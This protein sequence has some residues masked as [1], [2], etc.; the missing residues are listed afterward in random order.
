VIDYTALTEKY[1]RRAGEALAL[2][3]RTTVPT[4]RRFV[5]MGVVVDVVGG[6]GFSI[7]FLV[8][9]FAGVGTLIVSLVSGNA[10][11]IG[12]SFVMIISGLVCAAFTYWLVHR[13]FR[14]T[15][16]PELWWRLDRFATANGLVFAPWS[17][18]PAFPS[19]MFR[20][21]AGAATYSHIRRDGDDFFNIG[22]LYYQTGKRGNETFD[23]R[24][25][26]VAIKLEQQW[27]GMLLDATA[28]DRLG[29]NGIP[30]DLA[31]TKMQKVVGTGAD[32]FV[33]WA[34][35]GDSEKGRQVFSPA[36][37]EALASATGDYDAHL[38]ED[39]LFILSRTEFDMADPALLA[40]LF[41]F[42]DV[43]RAARV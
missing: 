31:G 26:F 22:N 9:F 2:R 35:P 5:G 37:V 17:P 6:I 40:E 1:D 25:G 23:K 19:A 14:S 21:G 18:E 13:Y 11:N 43:V 34:N 38:V 29:M 28:N 8:L 39:W 36:L 4:R 10:E 30:L 27:P 7:G 32:E 15:G 20:A 41:G 16:N 42:I 24:W 3:L 12:V 33:L